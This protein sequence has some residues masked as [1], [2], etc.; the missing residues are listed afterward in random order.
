M[1]TRLKNT[2]LEVVLINTAETEDTVFSF[3]GMVAPDLIPLMDTDGLTTQQWQ[4]RG[5]PSTFLIDPDGNRRYLA[6]GG[7]TWDS[8]EFLSFLEH[9]VKATD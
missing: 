7:R 5:L 4:P 2:S 9:L 3:L 1:S 6:L 8:N